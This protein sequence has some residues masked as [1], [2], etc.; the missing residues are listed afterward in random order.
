MTE[1]Q[2]QKKR[3]DQLEKEGYYVLKLVKTNK[4]GIP[5]I[6]AIPPNTPVIFSEVKTPKGKT[7]VIQD[8]RLKELDKYGFITEIYR[9]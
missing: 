3:I 5:D 4:N 2:I 1:Q 7:S 9:G 6:V 8:Y